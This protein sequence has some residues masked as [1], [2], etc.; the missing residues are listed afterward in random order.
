MACNNDHTYTSYDCKDPC[1]FAIKRRLSPRFR[2]L[3]Y[4]KATDEAIWEGK[5]IKRADPIPE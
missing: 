3:T 5:V 2:V 1:V 4:D